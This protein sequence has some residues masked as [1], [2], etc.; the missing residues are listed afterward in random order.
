MMTSCSS[1]T[2]V[3]DCQKRDRRWHQANWKSSVTFQ[4]RNL[5]EYVKVEQYVHLAAAIQQA[6]TMEAM[7]KLIEEISTENFS[8]RKIIE[9][10]MSWEYTIRTT[11]YCEWDFKYA[12]D[13]I[14]DEEEGRRLGLIQA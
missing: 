4:G 6:N 10:S 5:L 8:S 9:I 13:D 12:S 11:L 7:Y 1:N 14:A 2:S 3:K